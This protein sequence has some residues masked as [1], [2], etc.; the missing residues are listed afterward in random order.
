MVAESQPIAKPE[1]TTT[2]FLNLL[3][4]SG[5][6]EPVPLRPDP[7]YPHRHL[8]G[9]GSAELVAH[10]E[11][12]FDPLQLTS[13]ASLNRTVVSHPVA[14]P[15]VLG[16][17]AGELCSRDALAQLALEARAVPEPSP[18][19][20]TDQLA[21]ALRSEQA[22]P[23]AEAAL[24]EFGRR[25]GAL[26]ATLVQGPAVFEASPYH[27]AYLSHWRR[28]EVL[29]LGGG[30]L[31]NGTATT[32]LGGVEEVL[33]R[34][35]VP[36]PVRVLP[37]APYAGLVG[38]A[39]LASPGAR[40]AVVVDLGHTKAK[41]AT[42]MINGQVVTGLV[43]RR[44]VAAPEHPDE[45]LPKVVEAV[46]AALRCPRAAMG[47]SELIT[48][49][50]AS[51]V[52]DGLPIYDSRGVYT[53]LGQHLDELEARLAMAAGH[54]VR[55]RFVHDGTAAAVAADEGQLGGVITLGSWL[56]VGFTP[57]FG[58]LLDVAPTLA[59]SA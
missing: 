18:A 10:D 42:A 4:E 22:R 23:P 20:L 26:I 36:R 49:S 29:S 48:F 9:P 1:K 13:S 24:R 33:D 39:R 44:S 14:S 51:Y 53:E 41:T 30:L 43:D 3:A 19:H 12:P 25:L 46:A 38:V 37:W 34:A 35:G 47:S 59:L 45:A 5:G 55:V 32:V 17:T 50:V 7:W 58:G 6:S 27:Q 2:M 54:R 52:R 11:W 8:P 40:S 21:R 15:G 16:R 31:A 56:A 57:T 28:V